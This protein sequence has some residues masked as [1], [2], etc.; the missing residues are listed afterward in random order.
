MPDLSVV[1]SLVFSYLAA[2]GG[3]FRSV[4]ALLAMRLTQRSAMTTAVRCC[5]DSESSTR[6]SQ[7][8]LFLWRRPMLVVLVVP[9]SSLAMRLYRATGC[10]TAFVDQV[11]PKSW[12]CWA[13]LD[14]HFVFGW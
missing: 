3:R 14:R 10:S 13:A 5:L 4:V 12:V 7:E 1:S 9:M 11:D 8:E 2:V 6:R